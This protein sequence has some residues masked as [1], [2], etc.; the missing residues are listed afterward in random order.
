M[1]SASNSQSTNPKLPFAV[2][3]IIYQALQSATG[4]VISL[5][6]HENLSYIYFFL[7]D[8]FDLK[9]LYLHSILETAELQLMSQLV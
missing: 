4:G 8:F 3:I 2:F 1:V 5:F 7:D 9:M 6:F